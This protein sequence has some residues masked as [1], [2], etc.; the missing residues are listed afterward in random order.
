LKLIAVALALVGGT[1]LAAGCSA[2][3]AASS[4]DQGAG[5]ATSGDDP[6]GATPPAFAGE[7]ASAPMPTTYR[8]NPLCH[9]ADDKCM[10]DD[11]GYSVT[12]RLANEAKHCADA[13]PDAGDA[14]TSATGHSPGCRIARDSKTSEVAPACDES[15][16]ASRDGGDGATCKTGG[17]CGPGFDCIVGEKGTK[18]CRHYCCAGTCKG[19][20]SQSGGATFCD[21]QNLVDYTQKAPV[22]MPLKRCKL[23]GSGECTQTESCAV[24]TESGDTGCVAVGPQQVGAPCDADHC[25]ANLTCVGKPGTRKCYKLCRVDSSDCGTAQICATSTVFKDPNFGICQKP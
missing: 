5:N 17:D 11:D 9:L 24:V 12:D 2:Q 4:L 25:A 21:V 13:P 23:L 1:A 15:E 7:D 19:H 14:G 3:T 20:A 22:C 16:N 8:G 6:N 18:V 10:P